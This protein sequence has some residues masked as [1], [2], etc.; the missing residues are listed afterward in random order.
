[1]RPFSSPPAVEK[2]PLAGFCWTERGRDGI[3]GVQKVVRH[4]R[5]PLTREAWGGRPD[6]GIGPYRDAPK[7]TPP[8]PALR[9]TFPPVW[10]RLDRAATGHPYVVLASFISLVPSYTPG[11]AHSAARPLPNKAFGFAGDPISGGDSPLSQGGIEIGGHR[12]PLRRIPRF[13]Y[14]VGPAPCGGPPIL[15]TAP[16]SVIAYGDATFPKGTAS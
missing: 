15:S 13:M 6:E 10:G 12:P 8:H 1:M 7:I 3:L 9:A 2:R 5:L 14:R 11:L 4:L 16:S